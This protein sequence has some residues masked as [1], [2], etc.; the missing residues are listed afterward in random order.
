M[1]EVLDIRCGGVQCDATARLT[2]RRAREQ[3]W[4]QNMRPPHPYKCP[5]CVMMQN[6]YQLDVDV[7]DGRN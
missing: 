1:E 7:R 3:G 5:D 2:Y 4:V 6:S